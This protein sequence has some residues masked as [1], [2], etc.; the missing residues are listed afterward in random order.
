MFLYYSLLNVFLYIQQ[1]QTSVA[2]H[3][4]AALKMDIATTGKSK[5]DMETG[6]WKTNPIS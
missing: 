2:S 1:F 6:D 3:S 4:I 5:H